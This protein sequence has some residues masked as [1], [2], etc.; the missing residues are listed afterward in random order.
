MTIKDSGCGISDE[1]LKKL[2]KNFGKLEDKNQ[3]NP[4]GVG[5]GLSICRE[6][7]QASGGN[8]DIKSELGKGTSFI[9][10]MSTICQLD[11]TRLL[12]A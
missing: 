2:F 10:S 6:I 11:E 3:V 4:G 9:I 7:I 12:N 5:L 8:I 1:D